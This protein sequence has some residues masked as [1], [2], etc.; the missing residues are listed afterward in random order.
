MDIDFSRAADI[1][2]VVGN[3][4]HRAEFLQKRLTGEITVRI[5]ERDHAF[6]HSHTA[7]ACEVYGTVCG[8]RFFLTGKMTSLGADKAVV[9]SLAPGKEDKRSTIRRAFAPVPARIHEKAPA[10]GPMIPATI[11]NITGTGAQVTTA[12]PLQAGKEY[13]LEAE[14]RVQYMVQPFTAVFRVCY[15]RKNGAA[16]VSGVTFDQASMRQEHKEALR[17]FLGTQ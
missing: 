17:S 16:C 7:S 2:I 5:V 8:E 3:R 14:F 4:T 15:C 13:T 9:F 6:T 1:V 12:T 10:V 11:V